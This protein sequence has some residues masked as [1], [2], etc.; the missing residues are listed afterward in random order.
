MKQGI[1]RW[2][3]NEDTKQVTKREIEVVN[4]TENGAMVKGL[5]PGDMIATAGANLL[6]E[7]QQ[8]RILE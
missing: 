7:G 3:V 2:I 5:K 8:V 4:L 1:T 6:V